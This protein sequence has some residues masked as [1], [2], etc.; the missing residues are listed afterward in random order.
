[1]PEQRS[2]PS[3][4]GAFYT[5]EHG[6]FAPTGQ[7]ISVWN[8]DAQMG[9]ALAGLAAHVLEDIASP[10]EMTTA[11]LTIDILGAVP[12]A[13]L[14]ARTRI[15]REGRRMQ[16]LE[17]ELGAGDR[18]WV[19]ASALRVRTASSPRAEPAPIHPFPDLDAGGAHVRESPY[20][21]TVRLRG[22]YPDPGPGAWWVRPRMAV[23]AGRPIRGLEALAMVS[24]YGSGVA[25]LV[26]PD[27]WTFA[28]V[29]VSL[30]LTRPLRGDWLLIA[31]ESESA[32]N[33]IGVTHSRLG[34]RDGMIGMAHQTV[35]LDRR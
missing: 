2:P 25:P 29:D 7:G 32:G 23:V 31:S 5:V 35:F 3:I 10:V 13:P 8:P 15:V 28:N 33:G 20:A 21:T 19:R 11:R 27:D 22:G 16:V 34:D 18:T 30:H 6:L 26:S 24:D 17:I 14:E 4:V 1:L 9:V 12:L